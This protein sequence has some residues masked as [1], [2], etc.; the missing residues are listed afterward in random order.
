MVSSEPAGPLE[1]AP[2][3]VAEFSVRGAFHLTAR[4]AFVVHGE[5]TP[6]EVRSAHFPM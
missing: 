2:E 5:V 3:P 4:R 6:G 1:P